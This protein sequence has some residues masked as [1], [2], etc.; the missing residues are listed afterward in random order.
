LTQALIWVA[1]IDG[2]L[3][4]VL[5][6]GGEDATL[7]TGVMI[8]TIFTGMFPAIAAVIIAQDAIVGERESGTAAW[9]LSK[10]VSRP[11][12]V[13]SKL[14][15]T[16]V[17][18]LVSM[19]LIP[20]LLAYGL[21]SWKAGAPLDVLSFLAAQGIFW[22]NLIFYLSLTIMLGA[23][24][25]H[26]GPVI[27]IPLALSFGQQ[28]LI[29]AAPFLARLLPYTL[30]VPLDDQHGS[31]AAAVIQGQTPPDLL[32]LLMTLVYIVLFVALALWRFEREEF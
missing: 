17:G 32:P 9:V 10:P 11:A 12:F 31:I 15:P 28:M 25:T 8:Y 30:A 24:F 26:R 22:I 14:V 1:V 18:T 2:I 21:L 20:G 6:T 19:I 29:G 3:F 7:E 4:S 27:G 16:A 5:R 23:F 13:V